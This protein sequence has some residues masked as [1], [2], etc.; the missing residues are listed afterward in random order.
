M[1]FGHCLLTGIIIAIVLF[2]LWFTDWRRRPP[3]G[4]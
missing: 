2:A 4:Y 1:T 3:P